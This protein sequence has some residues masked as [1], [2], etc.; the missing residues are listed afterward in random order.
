MTDK[1][2]QLELRWNTP[3]GRI[4]PRL[5]RQQVGYSLG[6]TDSDQDFSWLFNRGDN[7]I[8]PIRFYTAKSRDQ[9]IASIVAVGDEACQKLCAILPILLTAV[10]SIEG[11]SAHPAV[12]PGQVH[13]EASPYNIPYRVQTI[14]LPKLR[15]DREFYNRHRAEPQLLVPYLQEAIA[16]GINRMADRFGLEVPGILPGAIEVL[17]VG[18]LGTQ[19]IEKAG[20]KAMLSRV[21][22]AKFL[23]PIKLQGDWRAGGLL[24]YGNGRITSIAAERHYRA[25]QDQGRGETPFP[26]YQMAS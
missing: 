20:R 3:A 12:Y 4:N 18:D 17:Q 19:P 25:P 15:G 9:G 23:L 13:W 22:Q 7:A 8:A 16:A 1:V 26:T 21:T 11:M 14:V 2:Q 6:A 5:F 24:S 10:R